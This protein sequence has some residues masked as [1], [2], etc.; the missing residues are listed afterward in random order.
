MT[1]TKLA[2]VPIRH[3]QA[4]GDAPTVAMVLVA[5][6]YSTR[7][8][9]PTFLRAG[10]VGA[11]LARAADESRGKREPQTGRQGGSPEGYGEGPENPQTRTDSEGQPPPAPCHAALGPPP[12]SSC[13]GD[14]SPANLRPTTEK[15]T[16]CQCQTLSPRARSERPR[17]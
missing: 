5:G 1:F 10:P 4:G 16:R 14:S 3:G 2:G 17:R 12:W 11:A 6:F 8:G 13:H 7:A 15:D 9:S